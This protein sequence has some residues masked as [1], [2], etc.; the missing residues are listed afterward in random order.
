MKQLMINDKDVKMLELL[1]KGGSSKE[2]A[3][4]LGFREGTMRVYLHNLYRKLG[5]KSKTS[6]VSWYLA[7]AKRSMQESGGEDMGQQS[8]VEESFGEMAMRTSLLASLGVMKIFFGAF[9][10]MWEVAARLK[11][12]AIDDATEQQR[13][14]SRLLWEAMLAGDFGYA[15]RL[16][17]RGLAGKLFID[18]P[19]DCLLLAM[20]LLLG[21]YSLSADKVIV[22]L[23]RREKGRLG[24]SAAEHRMIRL[25]RD[26]VNDESD[27]ALACLYGMAE[28]S[29]SQ[30]VFRHAVMA[31]LHYVYKQRHDHERAVG[32]ANAIWAEAEGVRQHLQ[33]MGEKPLYKD[34]SLPAPKVKT[35]LDVRAYLEKLEHA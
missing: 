21:G 32:V 5:V 28:E 18:S 35:G 10:R 26:A 14:N 7:T 12:E 23:K 2:M 20:M 8:L 33:A 30:Q 22:L 25:L 6:A 1:A 11:G 31:A 3:R 15:K 34:A 29:G 19:P 27:E 9:G 16:A 17:D 24:V 13:R 4:D